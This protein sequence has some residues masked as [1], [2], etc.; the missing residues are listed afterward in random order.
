MQNKISRDDAQSELVRIRRASEKAADRDPTENVDHREMTPEELAAAFRTLAEFKSLLDRAVALR[1][2]IKTAGLGLDLAT[3]AAQLPLI[4]ERMLG[5]LLNSLRLPGGDHKLR[6]RANHPRLEDCGINRR[7]SHQWRLEAELP[8][9][10]FADYL[11]QAS[12]NGTMPSSHGLFRLAKAYV[13]SARQ[14]GHSAD[15]LCRASGG[16]ERLASEGKRFGCI[17]IDAAFAPA[18]GA[19]HA[20]RSTRDWPNCR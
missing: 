12:R 14:A 2:D 8:P 5:K 7:Q 16:V 4:I 20:V 1:S 15:P 13:E 19:K 18:D 10:A 17:F 11:A 3:W 9:A 6:H